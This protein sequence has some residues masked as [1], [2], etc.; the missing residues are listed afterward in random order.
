MAKVENEINNPMT[1]PARRD[2]LKLIVAL[3]AL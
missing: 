1:S 3:I 2:L